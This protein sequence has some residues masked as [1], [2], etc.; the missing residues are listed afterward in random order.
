MERIIAGAGAAGGVDGTVAGAG[1]P[2]VVQ[3]LFARSG[4]S[5][6]GRLPRS[7]A[8]W[9]TDEQPELNALLRLYLANRGVWEAIETA[10]PAMSVAASEDDVAL[11]LAAFTLFVTDVTAPA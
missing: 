8:E 3:R 6:C 4:F 5:F 7:A 9:D 10:G 2:W 1:L 11:Y